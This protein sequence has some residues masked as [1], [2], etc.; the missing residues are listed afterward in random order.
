MALI[1]AALVADESCLASQNM[2]W[3]LFGTLNDKAIR[4][5]LS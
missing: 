5:K 4:M 2:S 1:L 3:F